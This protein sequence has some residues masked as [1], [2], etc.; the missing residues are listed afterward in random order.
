[1]IV[2]DEKEMTDRR[3]VDWVTACHAREVE[4][5]LLRYHNM[6]AFLGDW[7]CK[8]LES[9]RRGQGCH[10][11]V[12]YLA[13]HWGAVF[14]Q[15]VEHMSQLLLRDA[16]S[17]CPRL[18]EKLRET[19]NQAQLDEALF[20]LELACLFL[21]HGHKIVV[22]PTSRKGP[23]LKVLLCGRD[24]YVEAKKL[25]RDADQQRR[26]ASRCGWIRIVAGHRLEKDE[27]NLHQNYLETNQFPDH[28]YHVMA[29]DTFRRTGG[30]ELMARAWNY[31]CHNTR[32]RSPQRSIHVLVLCRREEQRHLC[33]LKDLTVGASV[34]HNPSAP[35]HDNVLSALK[36]IFCSQA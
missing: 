12:G 32:D 4:R 14:A 36:E 19:S 6:S 25:E 9:A 5:L 23:D 16:P 13:S 27:W 34:L 26:R 20:E 1:V 21:R 35:I 10:A 2:G 18:R 33:W 7:I 30:A 8:E 22:E 28:G 11:L 31:Y 29:V 24:V 15:K 3:I 17:Q